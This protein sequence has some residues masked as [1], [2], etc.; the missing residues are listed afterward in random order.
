MSDINPFERL[1]EHTP[2]H[3]VL[4]LACCVAHGSPGG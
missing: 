1:A 2:E 3:Y 4:V